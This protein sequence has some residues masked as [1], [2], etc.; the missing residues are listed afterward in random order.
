MPYKRFYR[1]S[2][3]RK[4]SFRRRSRFVRKRSKFNRPGKKV[5]SVRQRGTFIADKTLCK[6]KFVQTSN[7]SSGSELTEGF[8]VYRGNSIFDPDQT[9]TGARPYGTAQYQALY[10]NYVV[11]GSSI[12]VVVVPTTNNV[13][14]GALQTIVFPGTTSSWGQTT[15]D[16]LREIPYAHSNEQSIYGGAYKV[17]HYFDTGKVFGLTRKEITYRESEYG[18]LFTASPSTQWYWNIYLAPL[19]QDVAS[20]WTGTI[21][22]KIIY[23]CRLRNRVNQAPST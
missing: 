23:Y 12:E 3:T 8:Q 5:T 13:D 16:Q 7:F 10:N 11:Y 4:S 6:L 1:R 21:Q 17:K 9:G 18:A 14:T 2:Y 22:T 15:L 20:A 19:S